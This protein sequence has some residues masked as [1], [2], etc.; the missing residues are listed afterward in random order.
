MSKFLV[1]LLFY[2]ET[3]VKQ[4]KDGTIEHCSLKDLE[5]KNLEILSD[6]SICFD[7]IKN[8]LLEKAEGPGEPRIKK[9]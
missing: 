1:D 4:N 6:V 5:D 2:G 8:Y 9:L 7:D 3:I